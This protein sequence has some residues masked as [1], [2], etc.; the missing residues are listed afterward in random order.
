MKQKTK[1]ANALSLVL[2]TVGMILV[3][4]AVAAVVFS[5]L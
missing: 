1:M 3:G 5:M 4:A 2:L